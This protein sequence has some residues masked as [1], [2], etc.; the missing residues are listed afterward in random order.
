MII[1]LGRRWSFVSK[2][3][4]RARTEEEVRE[5]I[6]SLIRSNIKFWA[7]SSR[8]TDFEKCEGVA[9]SILDIF[10][11]ATFVLPAMDISLSPHPD[12]KQ[13]NIEHGNNW[14]EPGM[15]ISNTILRELL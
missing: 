6:L 2:D 10:D 4:P 13:F 3:E 9:F 5:E 8:K 11:G 7:E 1:V 14:Y 12:D 15:I